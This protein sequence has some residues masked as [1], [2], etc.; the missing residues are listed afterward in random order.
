VICAR[1]GSKGLKD[2]NFA[3]VQDKPLIWYSCNAA[4]SAKSLSRTLVSSDSDVIL[5]LAAEYGVETLK[6]P[7]QYATD[8]SRIEEAMIHALEFAESDGERYDLVALLQN[9][10]P[11]R[12]GQD[13]DGAVAQMGACWD[14]ADSVM[15]VNT[16]IGSHPL[17]MK[18]ITDGGLLVPFIDNHGLYRRQDYPP[19]FEENGCVYVVKRSYLLEHHRVIAE[20]CVPYFIDPVRSFDVHDDNDLI[21]VE[22]LMKKRGVGL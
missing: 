13:I 9:S 12:I 17:K 5:S 3:K 1:A 21:V 2:K 7:D 14:E 4:L 22:A 20:R 6:R 11:M 15:S 8:T 16:V 10:S 19:V 18:K